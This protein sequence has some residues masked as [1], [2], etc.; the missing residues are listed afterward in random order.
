MEATTKPLKAPS[1][2]DAAS[3]WATEAPPMSLAM[4]LPK[5][6]GSMPVNLENGVMTDVKS[7]ANVGAI[8]IMPTMARASVPAARMPFSNS[9]PNL[10]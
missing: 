2:S 5:T 1:V 6:E 7:C 9:S 10:K 3:S 8:Q 4:K